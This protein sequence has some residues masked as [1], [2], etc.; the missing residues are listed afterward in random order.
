MLHRLLL[1][2]YCLGDVDHHISVCV[3]TNVCRYIGYKNV[4]DPD[5]T[6]EDDWMPKGKGNYILG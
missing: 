3:F 1:V 4:P 5:P 6:I 2:D